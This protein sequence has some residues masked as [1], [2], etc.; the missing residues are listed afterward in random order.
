M[1]PARKL[2]AV[3]GASG[4]LSFG[5]LYQSAV[6]A[7]VVQLDVLVLVVGM[8]VAGAITSLVAP[9]LRRAIVARR[10]DASGDEGHANPSEEHGLAEQGGEDS[11]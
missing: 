11:R 5:V 1:D 10:V 6:L 4:A 3:M 7:G 8:A 9:R 2:A